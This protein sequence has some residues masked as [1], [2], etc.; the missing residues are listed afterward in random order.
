MQRVSLKDWVILLTIIPTTVIS[1]GLAGYFSYSRSVDLTN[2]LEQQA[3]SIIEPIAI[4]SK[5]LLQTKNNKELRDLISLTHRSQSNIINHIIIFNINHQMIVSSNYHGDTD[6]MRLSEN[7]VIPIVTEAEDLDNYIIFRSPIFNEN[8]PHIYNRIKNNQNTPLFA[9]NSSDTLTTDNNLPRVIGYIAIQI[10][11]NKINF[12]QQRQ[13]IIAF[14]FAL[15]ASLLSSIF[16][17]KLIKKVTKPIRSMIL[18]IERVS[19]GKLDSRVP[20]KL[21]GELN[22]LKGGINSMAQS[23]D[24]YQ[25]EMQGNIDQATIDLRESLE[26]FEIQNVELSIANRKEQEANKVKS[27]FLANMSHELRTPLNG[28]IGFTRQVLKTPL[29]DNQ[30]EHLQI[31][32][33][34]ANNLLNIINDIL[35]FSKL[36][37]GKMVIEKMPFSLRE[38]IEETLT[39]IAPSAHKKNIELSININKDTP[40][41]LVGD[42]MRIKQI[43]V[44]LIGNAIKFT[45]QGGVTIDIEN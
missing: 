38:S 19:E 39:L 4:A 2:N 14:A 18:A 43:I 23:L 10:D 32:D 41:S 37:A 33:R 6:L 13:Y 17:I 34:S 44:N 45:Q 22:S 40:D 7:K 31:I 20:G 26:Q 16:A 29:S 24:N 30:R 1:F 5:I 8:M 27:E 11:K 28:V 12:T 35:D 42:I 21:I 3:K 15:L 25:V 36:D 9:T